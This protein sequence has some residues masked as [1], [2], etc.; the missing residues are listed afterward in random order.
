MKTNLQ[1]PRSWIL[2]RGLARSQDHWG[3][4]LQI[5]KTHFPQDDIEL[6]DLAGN[7]DQRHRLSYLR[8]RD[9]VA[10][11]RARSQFSREKRQVSLL[12]LSLGGML[13]VE[14]ASR[15]PQDIAHLVLINTS[16]R[17]HAHFYERLCPKAY[18]GLLKV[19]FAKNLIQ[20]ERRILE[21]TA[22]GFSETDK[23]SKTFARARGTNLINSLAQL[24]S[25]A[26]YS[27][28][29]QKPHCPTLILSGLKDQLVD[30][31]CSE[32]LAL[33]WGV[34]HKK[35]PLGGHD[36]P[37]TQPEWI[38]QTLSDWLASYQ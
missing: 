16:D 25:A 29:A 35:N 37:L 18:P 11:L 27:F 4:F 38:C 17:L 31:V 1:T 34:P 28:P 9:A 2:L 12:T 24:F 32:R 22:N 30:P 8:L 26:T 33:D 10:D 20:K 7:G 23:W 13:G 36:L 21:I 19:V 5:F 3:P 14:W 15:F 6:L